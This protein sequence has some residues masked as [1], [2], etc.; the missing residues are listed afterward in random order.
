MEKTNAKPPIK[1]PEIT[2]AMFVGFI[3]GFAVS[4]ML[5][6]F[7]AWVALNKRQKELAAEYGLAMAVIVTE[8]IAAGERLDPDKL[9]KRALPQLVVSPNAVLPDEVDPLFGKTPT[10]SFERGDILLRSAFGLEPR[11][12]LAPQATEE[13]KM[14]KPVGEGQPAPAAA[15]EAHEAHEAPATDE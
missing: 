2:G 14:P 10:I 11:T 9:A 13:D 1:I 5:A 15:P 3:V 4:A 8:P 6:S 12:G 7:I